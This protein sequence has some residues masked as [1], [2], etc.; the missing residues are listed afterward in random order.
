VLKAR[1]PCRAPYRPTLAGSLLIVGESGSHRSHRPRRSDVLK[2]KLNPS[3]SSSSLGSPAIA[4]AFTV[5]E[6]PR[7]VWW[8][9]WWL[10]VGFA[11]LSWERP[12]GLFLLMRLMT[13]REEIE[14]RI[15]EEGVDPEKKCKLV[16]MAQYGNVMVTFWQVPAS[17][18]G[19]TSYV[20]RLDHSGDFTPDGSP[21]MG[22]D[23]E[24]ARG[25]LLWARDHLDFFFRIFQ[26]MGDGLLYADD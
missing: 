23:W 15:E 2:A 26:I 4:V 6:G 1:V 13:Q 7:T 10:T 11:G 17:P 22:T 24:T 14:Q 21:L 3:D 20:V 8:L 12:R 25:C 18:R 5:P 16:D 9:M 19:I